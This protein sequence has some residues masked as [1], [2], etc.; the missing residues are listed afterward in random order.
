MLLQESTLSTDKWQI[1]IARN[2]LLAV[3]VLTWPGK[4]L[5]SLR[6]NCWDYRKGGKT[7]WT[8]CPSLVVVQTDG[9]RAARGSVQRSCYCGN[10]GRVGCWCDPC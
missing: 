5:N 10:Q 8:G 4:M 6:W 3:A 9:E 1:S 2:T 7:E